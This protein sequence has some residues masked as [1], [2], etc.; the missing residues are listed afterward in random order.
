MY[1]PYRLFLVLKYI[2]FIAVDNGSVFV[3]LTF[4][5]LV[6]VVIQMHMP[7]KKIF[8]LILVQQFPEGAKARVGKVFPIVELIGGS[9]GD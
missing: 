1:A 8:W 7:V 9:M 4:P 2:F 6:D 5:L 3:V